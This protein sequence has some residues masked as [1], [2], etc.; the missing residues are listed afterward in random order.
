MYQSA[1]APEIQI[2][3]LTLKVGK[4]VYKDYSKGGEP[5]V[6][7][8]NINLDERYQNIDDPN[9]LVS[10]IIVKALANTTIAKLTNFDLKGLEGTIGDTLASAQKVVGVAQETLMKTTGEAGKVVEGT[11]ETLK[12]TA[13]SLKEGLGLFGTKKE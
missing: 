13:E 5:S 6:Q 2:D 8:F 10:L 4:V 11:T 1:K 3:S 7:E 12:K 9:K